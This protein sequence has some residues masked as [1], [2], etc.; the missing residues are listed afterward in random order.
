MSQSSC[1]FSIQLDER[2]CYQRL[3]AKLLFTDKDEGVKL[4]VGDTTL[5]KDKTRTTSSMLRDQQLAY[6]LE[7]LTKFPNQ[8]KSFSLVATHPSSNRW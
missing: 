4:K 2:G 1:P 6:H 5:A 8:E 7:S 3:N